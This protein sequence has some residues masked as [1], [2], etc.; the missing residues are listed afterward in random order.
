[1]KYRLR[2]KDLTNEAEGYGD[3]DESL[4]IIKAWVD[5]ANT[6]YAGLIYHWIEESAE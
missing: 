3:W 1:M 5:Y 4:L 6:K 2:W